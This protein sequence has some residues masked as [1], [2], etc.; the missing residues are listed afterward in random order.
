MKS[1]YPEENET[2]DDVK[3]WPSNPMTWRMLQ[4]LL[5]STRC[6]ELSNCVYLVDIRGIVI[7]LLIKDLII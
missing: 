6:I 7:S 2:S 1:G 5:H 4:L 3:M